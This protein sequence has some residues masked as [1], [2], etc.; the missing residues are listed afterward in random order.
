[1]PVT[2][3][4]R[5]ER[6]RFEGRIVEAVGTYERYANVR[7]VDGGRVRPVR[8]CDLITE[9]EEDARKAERWKAREEAHQ[10]FLAS[11]RE[12]VSGRQ[13]YFATEMYAND[14]LVDW[15]PN[16]RR[17][18]LRLAGLQW[19]CAAGRWELKDKKGQV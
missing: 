19:N 4:K 12:F 14:P 1:M 13:W 17:K 15:R 5:G 3:V 10:R 18:W 7:Y 11:I 9:A 6:F 8:C 16:T 2:E